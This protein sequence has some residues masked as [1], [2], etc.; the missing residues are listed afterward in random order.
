MLQKTH[1]KI[2]KSLKKPSKN[3]HLNILSLPSI[4]STYFPQNLIFIRYKKISSKNFIKGIKTSHTISNVA[5]YKKRKKKNENLAT[6]KKRNSRYKNNK[7]KCHNFKCDH[8][9]ENKEK[10]RTEKRW[11]GSG[12]EDEKTSSGS[13]NIF[14]SFSLFPFHLIKKNVRCLH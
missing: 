9:I 11:E 3:F 4:K 7:K 5:K 14:P 1:P 8:L 13:K 2:D 6:L 10:K 12:N